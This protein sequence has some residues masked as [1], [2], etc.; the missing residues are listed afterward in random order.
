[1]GNCKHPDGWRVWC[2][3]PSCST[4]GTA[5]HSVWMRVACLSAWC[6]FLPLWLALR[7]L[8]PAGPGLGEVSEQRAPFPVLAS[9]CPPG[10]RCLKLIYF[11]VGAFQRARVPHCSSWDVADTVSLQLVASVPWFSVVLSTISLLESQL[12]GVRIQTGS[13][14]ALW[15]SSQDGSN[16]TPPKWSPSPRCHKLFL[17]LECA[18]VRRCQAGSLLRE[19]TGEKGQHLHI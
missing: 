17:F 8:I 10:A 18:S 16:V 5:V 19:L 6:L 14:L 2:P 1:M 3:S 12:P 11:L 4:L 9:W 15:W 13:S 7:F